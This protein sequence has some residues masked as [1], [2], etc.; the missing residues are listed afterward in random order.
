VAEG[1]RHRIAPGDCVDSVARSYGF[2]W[3]TLW[4]HPENR[5]LRDLRK[6]PNVLLPGDELFVPAR[7]SGSVSVQTGGTY[8]FKAKFGSPRIRLRLTSGTESRAQVPFVLELDGGGTQSGTTTP[9]GIV[10]VVVPPRARSAKLRI[11]TDLGSE[12]YLVKLGYLDPASEL[13]G[14][15]QRLSNL[16][17]RCDVTGEL[18]ERTR[19]ALRAFQTASSLEA[20]GD[21]NDQTRAKLVEAHG[22]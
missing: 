8:R 4:D 13:A 15:Q 22:S 1:R 2:F 18:D 11:E 5:E 9:D 17:F 21:V 3:R 14:V 16:G 12:V 19:D 7:T 10:D 20:T 6:D